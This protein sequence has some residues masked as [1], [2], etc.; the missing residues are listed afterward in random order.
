LQ[1][2]CESFVLGVRGELLILAAVARTTSAAALRPLAMAPCTVPLLAADIG[3]LASKNKVLA[4][5]FP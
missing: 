5:P 4:L 1:D 2:V 3:G